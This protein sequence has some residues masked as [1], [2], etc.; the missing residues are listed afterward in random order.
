MSWMDVLKFLAMCGGVVAV[1]GAFVW[2]RYR[3]ID[4]R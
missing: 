3:S 4:R 2:I 1:Y